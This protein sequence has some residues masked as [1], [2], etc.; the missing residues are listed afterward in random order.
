MK[1]SYEDIKNV[2]DLRFLFDQDLQE[3][4]NRLNQCLET[5]REYKGIW[6]NSDIEDYVFSEMDATESCELEEGCL[7]WDDIRDIQHDIVDYFKS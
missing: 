5:A 1:K 2:I 7:M 6:E 3:T 4:Y